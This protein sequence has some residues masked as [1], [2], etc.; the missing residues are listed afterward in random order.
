MEADLLGAQR[1][2]LAVPKNRAKYRNVGRCQ[3]AKYTTLAMADADLATK[4][5]QHNLEA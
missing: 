2:P 3:Q 5:R 1:W 4:V